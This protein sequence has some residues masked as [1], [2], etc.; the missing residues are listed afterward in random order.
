[1]VGIPAWRSRDLATWEQLPRLWQLS[2]SQWIQS[3]KPDGKPLLIWAPELHLIGG[4]WVLVHT[5]NARG[6]NLLL[7]SVELKPPFSEPIG[8]AFG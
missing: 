8:A 4:R 6:A 3:L 7:G 5:T 2:D 1:V